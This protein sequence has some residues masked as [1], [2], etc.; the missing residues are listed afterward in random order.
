MRIAQMICEIAVRADDDQAALQ[1]G[2]RHVYCAARY[3]YPRA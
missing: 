2:F 3:S 1:P